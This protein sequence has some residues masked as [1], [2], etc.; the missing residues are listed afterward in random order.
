ML[1]LA[2]GLAG[3]LLALWGKELLRTYFGTQIP[4]NLSGRVLAFNIAVAF[5]TGLVFGVVPALR[6]TRLSVHN[7]MKGN[8]R[9]A[10]LQSR[11]A[12]NRSLVAIQV[13][14]AVVLLVGAGLLMQSAGNW[15]RLDMGFNPEEFVVFDAPPIEKRDAGLYSRLAERIREAPGVRSVSTAG[16]LPPSS[17]SSGLSATDVDN[18]RRV[19]A[20]RLVVPPEFFETM[21]ISLVA[22]RSFT[23]A[24]RAAGTG[25]AIVDEELAGA[26]YPQSSPIGKR[27][28]FGSGDRRSEFEI[29][30]VVENVVFDVDRSEIR[31]NYYIPDVEAGGNFGTSF[32]VR[33][34]GTPQKV[35]PEIRQAVADVNSTFPIF[36]LTTLQQ[37]VEQALSRQHQMSATWI[38]FGCAALFLTA[39]GLYGLTSY[40]VTRRIN[41]IGIRIALGA[42]SE[43]VV[44]LVIRQILKLVAAGMAAGFVLSLILTQVLRS[45]VFGVKTVE[46]WTLVAVGAIVT[47]VSAVASYLPARKG[48]R[49]DPVTALRGD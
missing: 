48:T 18:A 11:P 27:F 44:I 46:I 32:V 5:I 20:R 45:Y 35:V 4:M 19:D 43:G 33:I 29:V 36:G 10:L 17:C 25:T 39:I 38:L 42:T 12:L 47:A 15:K 14:M 37:I 2:G 24:D 21:G 49:I 28:Y 16:C 34:A 22:G 6:A 31:P 41:E 23:L 13:A 26:L 7:S 40:S 3:I 30:G 1:S 9:I 8:A